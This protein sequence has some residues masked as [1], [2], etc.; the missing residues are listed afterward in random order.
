MMLL[1]N[2]AQDVRGLVIRLQD[3]YA[4]DARA[5]DQRVDQ[6]IFARILKFLRKFSDD[7]DALKNLHSYT[8]LSCFPCSYASF[9]ERRSPRTGDLAD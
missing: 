8:E 5:P 7:L 9:S 3:P 4:D 1:L 2:H 6:A